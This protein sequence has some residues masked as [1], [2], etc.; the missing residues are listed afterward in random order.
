MLL[1]PDVASAAKRSRKA[2]SAAEKATMDSLDQ[3]A[4]QAYQSRNFAE[5]ARLMTEM[6]PLVVKAYGK[7][8]DDNATLHGNLGAIY[9][10]MSNPD[11]PEPRML[12]L[13]MEH[14]KKSLDVYEKLYGRQSPQYVENSSNY[15]VVLAQAGQKKNIGKILEIRRNNIQYYRAKGDTAKLAFENYAHGYDCTVAAEEAKT[16]DEKENFYSSA[17]GEILSLPRQSWFNGTDELI[18]ELYR[19]TAML[20]VNQ[21]YAVAGTDSRRW[22]ECELKAN[23]LLS[24]GEKYGLAPIWKSG[25]DTRLASIYGNMGDRTEAVRR[26]EGILQDVERRGNYLGVNLATVYGNLGAAYSNPVKSQQAYMKGLEIC[27]TPNRENVDILSA[28]YASLASGYLNQGKIRECDELLASWHGI[29]DGLKSKQSEEY[30][31][32]LK[33]KSGVESAK[34]NMGQAFNDSR[35]AYRII[36]GMYP[37]EDARALDAEQAMFRCS[38]SSH[39]STWPEDFRQLLQHSSGLRVSNPRSYV[40][41]L[42][43]GANAYREA[44][45]YG[46][47]LQLIDESIELCRQ[48]P[49]DG[50]QLVEGYLQG[51]ASLLSDMYRYDEAVAL[52]DSLIARPG[53]SETVKRSSY[54]TRSRIHREAGAYRDAIN[55]CLE[56]DRLLRLAGAEG[57]RG[58]LDDMTF[59]ASCYAKLG[60]TD[61]AYNLRRENVDIA[62]RL[63]GENSPQHIRAQVILYNTE[64]H[65]SLAQMEALMLRNMEAS[66][67]DSVANPYGYFK[68]CVNYA[69]TLGQLGD[70]KGAAR[71]A[72]IAL[73]GMAAL[74]NE[75]DEAYQVLLVNGAEIFFGIGDLETAAGLAQKA[76]DLT[77][78]YHPYNLNRQMTA[79]SW[80]IAVDEKNTDYG[81]QLAHHKEYEDLRKNKNG[82]YGLI[83]LESDLSASVIY[84]NLG[85]YEKVAELSERILRIHDTAIAEKNGIA[86]SPYELAALSNLC[87][88]MV[89]DRLD[90]K[91]KLK[92]YADRLEG[93]LNARDDIGDK[94]LLPSLHN[95]SNAYYHLG[96]TVRCL[97]YGDRLL[98]GLSADQGEFLPRAEALQGLHRIELGHAEEGRRL[99]EH[100]LAVADTMLRGKSSANY[101]HI[102]R[103]YVNGAD[104]LGDKSR[105]NALAM[106]YGRNVRDYVS[107]SFLNMSSAIRATFWNKYSPFLMNDFHGYVAESGDTAM[108]RAAYDNLLL[109]KGLLL[110]TDRGI[111]EAIAETGDSKVAAAYESYNLNRLTLARY[112]AGGDLL[113]LNLDS[114]ARV[115]DTQEAFLAAY[116]GR[117]SDNFNVGWRNVR[118]ALGKRE[119]AVEFAEYSD[120]CDTLDNRHYMAYVL[121]R[122]SESPVAVALTVPRSALNRRNFPS[123]SEAVWKP[124]AKAVGDA[125]RIYFS[126]AGALHAVP[127]E[128]LADFESKDKL[129]SD[130][131][132]LYRVSST[133][134]VGSGNRRKVRNAVIYGGISYD[135]DV[136][137]LQKEAEKYGDVTTQPTRTLEWLDRDLGIDTLMRRGVAYLP[138]TLAE[139]KDIE[140]RLNGRKITTAMYTGAEGTETSFKA[141]SG[142]RH[143]VIHIATHGFALGDSK[144]TGKA[145]RMLVGDTET[146]PMSREDKV[147]A[148]SGLLMAGANNRLRAKPM[149]DN[150]DDGIL[151][152]SEIAGMDL[153]GVDMVVMSACET[154]LGKTENDGVYG[155]QRAFKKAGV[156][157]LVASLWPVNDAATSLLMK[158]FYELLVQGKSKHQALT[159]AQKF[160]RENTDYTQPQY[161][162]PF[163]LID[164]LN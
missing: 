98:A 140:S 125:E 106:E 57:V 5:A 111:R 86:H 156:N 101:L 16:A 4:G 148:R 153:R 40:Y 90:D 28:L 105:R 112:Q 94:A 63:H 43:A 77:R 91:E 62:A 68:E 74:D 85:D 48:L 87:C 149:P 157:A 72:R 50:T 42:V 71:Y 137:E 23:G 33:T 96:D 82:S 39:S 47:A 3:L 61:S 79:L 146:V 26:L 66:R 126:P 119:A 147:M 145:Q 12:K 134:N 6:E 128:S 141:L 25:S 45:R 138:G 53:V 46:E 114:L 142:G 17:I 75:Q 129:V 73:D 76:L 34:G 143:D 69:N 122:D 15:A 127:L 22:L 144:A 84:G 102:L 21:G 92:T 89:P 132:D 64:G 154:G 131:W 100:G 133:R 104:I 109:G 135:A 164:G 93:C 67:A 78:K 124:L 103:S 163:I 31:T 20:Y 159:G 60:Q 81:A 121:R 65:K 151:H 59:L 136:E 155:L 24:E 49:Y 56:Y 158:K 30:S 44:G 88:N 10:A 32:Y 80:L 123:L 18:G 52:C 8:S 139:A 118:K 70:L 99:M 54:L 95:L 1:E 41:V 19:R 152:S 117:L 120:A 113:S 38:Y 37:A 55:D 116:C 36:R 97:K 7:N 9:L 27:G 162:A 108:T 115:T 110:D 83:D 58:N 150:V 29:F 51:K 2:V 13:S 14:M 161:W 107:G 130:R 11:S 160:L 35:E